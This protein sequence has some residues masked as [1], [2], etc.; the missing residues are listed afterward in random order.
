MSWLDAL[1]RWFDEHGRK[2]FWRFS[3][4][5]YVTIVAE[6]MLV[7]TRATTVE[8]VLKDFLAR[9]PTPRDLCNASDEDVVP[10]FK[11]LGLI[12]RS[13][14]VRKIVCTILEKYGGSIPCSEEDLEELPGIGRYLKNVILTKLCSIPRPFVDTNVLRVLSRYLG[15]DLD[16]DSAERWLSENVPPNLLY[17]TN[18][19]LM[20]V[21][22]VLCLPREP[23]CSSCPLRDWCRYA[24]Q[25]S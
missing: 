18:L 25:C 4:D 20:D 21:G 1:L 24:E 12:K 17:K 7:R 9:F 19:A 14:W 3:N 6:I 16:V 2:Y 11:R 15:R 10:F 8:R 22:A 23:R 5:W 13:S